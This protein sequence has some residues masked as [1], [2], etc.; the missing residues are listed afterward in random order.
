MTKKK[1]LLINGPTDILKNLRK[2]NREY[3]KAKQSFIK[4]SEFKGAKPERQKKWEYARNQYLTYVQEIYG[5]D[6]DALGE[7][8]EI[9][10]HLA[11][12]A[13]TQNDKDDN[14]EQ[15]LKWYK[16]SQKHTKNN[17][18]HHI[19]I[20]EN[21][22]RQQKLSDA[23]QLYQKLLDSD[24]VLQSNLTCLINAGILA[25]RAQDKNALDKI[26]KKMRE[27]HP[28]NKMLRQL[29]YSLDNLK[30]GKEGMGFYDGQPIITKGTA[31]NLQW[32]SQWNGVLLL[33]LVSGGATMSQIKEKWLDNTSTTELVVRTMLDVGRDNINWTG[34]EEGDK[35]IVEE[36]KLL[37]TNA[38]SLTEHGKEEAEHVE[39]LVVEVLK[40]DIDLDPKFGPGITAKLVDRYKKW[41]NIP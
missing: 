4:A 13:D 6:I 14:Y 7:L 37:G 16:E 25:V 17:P 11:Q 9:Y 36:T 18:F 5:K 21:F 26:I 3:Q 8:G 19:R 15:A 32:L 39:K 30:H 10:T 22:I 24:S 31:K 12:L 28:D 38:I 2:L 20:A 40:Q 33:L 41:K 1:E 34:K 35:T 23:L 27:Y 29:T